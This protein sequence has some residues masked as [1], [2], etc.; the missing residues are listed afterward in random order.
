MASEE[1][2]SHLYNTL[3]HPSEEERQIS[4]SCHLRRGDIDSK[5]SC[6]YELVHFVGYFRK[7]FNLTCTIIYF[8]MSCFNS[9]K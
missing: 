8:Y 9:L 6:T 4:F 1:E 2:Q 5:Q 3:L 7:Y